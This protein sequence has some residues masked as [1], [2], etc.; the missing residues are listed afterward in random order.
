MRAGFGIAAVCLAASGCLGDGAS[1]APPPATDVIPERPITVQVRLQAAHD[2]DTLFLRVRF[3]ASEEDTQHESWRRLGGA[4]QLEGGGF[5][6]L[7]AAI[8]GDAERGDVTRTSAASEAALA[9]LIDDPTSVGRLLN[10]QTTGCFGQCHERQ[11]HMPNWRAADGPAP[12]TVWTGVG[13]ADL[14]IWRGQR[15]ALAGF[16]DDLSFTPTGYVPDA[17]ASPFTPVALTTDGL[18]SFVFDPAGGDGFARSWTTL[19]TPFV[20]DDGTLAELPDALAIGTAMLL[21]YTP[22]D[23]DTV[24]AQVLSVPGG[25]R[26]DVTALS[27]VGDGEW[28]VV[29]TRKLATGDAVGDLAFVSGKPYGIA[30]SLHRN[31]AD[32]RDHY[33][34][35]PLTLLL[36]TAG[37]GVRAVSMA[38]TA[39]TPSF[40]DETMFPVTELSLF[41]PGVTSFEWLVGAPTTREGAP[42]TADVVHGGAFEVASA[43]NGCADCHAIRATDPTP[44]VMDA[45]PLERLVLRRG[46]VFTETPFFEEAAP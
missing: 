35:L 41:L 20:F 37:E 11:R 21:G 8:D 15:S 40:S 22:A 39:A 45:G 29:L 1:H 18:P 2:D 13:K 14:W 19:P 42:R 26:A 28:D 43:Q 38:G 25:S 6:D 17:G 44:P 9:V 7:Q 10:F 12:M 36:D 24:P 30:L 3:P 32:G 34:S 27:L 4:W 5:R 46:G 33:V 16:A 23:D 31:R